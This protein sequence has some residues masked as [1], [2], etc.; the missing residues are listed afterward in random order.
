M[1]TN[2]ER[3]NVIH[4]ES[5]FTGRRLTQHTSSGVG[6]VRFFWTLA[7]LE[8]AAIGAMCYYM[9]TIINSLLK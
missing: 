3:S 8:W 5:C 6:L 2:A 1:Q 4:A 9:A 7:F